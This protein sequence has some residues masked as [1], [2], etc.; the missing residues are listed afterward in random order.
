LVGFLNEKGGI[1][2]FA[3]EVKGTESPP[4]GR[5]QL[6]RSTFERFANSNIPGLLLVADVKGNRLYYAWLSARRLTG[7]MSVS[8]PVTE[9]DDASTKALRKQL[10]A[11]NGSVAVAG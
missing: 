4:P 8:I 11:A 1:N 2:T 9:L 5:F 7:T 10:R 3:I 6:T